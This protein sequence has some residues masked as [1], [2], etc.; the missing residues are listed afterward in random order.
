MS[1]LISGTFSAKIRISSGSPNDYE[2]EAAREGD[3]EVLDRIVRRNEGLVHSMAHRAF[4]ILRCNYRSVD[5]GGVFDDALNEGRIGVCLA[6]RGYNPI[7]GSWST[8]ASYW[9]RR[10]IWRFILKYVFGEN[11]KIPIP[12]LALYSQALKLPGKEGDTALDKAIAIGGFKKSQLVTIDKV[13]KAVKQQFRIDWAPEE[14]IDSPMGFS[15]PRETSSSDPTIPA[16]T[17]DSMRVLL[18]NLDEL[19]RRKPKYAYVLK[20]YYGLGCETATLLEI[21]RE[22]GLVKESARQ[23]KKKAIAMLRR[24]SRKELHGED[25]S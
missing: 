10:E 24:M 21:G 8:Y 17:K 16:D 12:A 5:D 18:K 19:E 23:Y 9:I 4:R 14:S 13:M 22:L 15:D 2:L 1:P 7:S 3:P 6:V 11:V 20:R 25:E